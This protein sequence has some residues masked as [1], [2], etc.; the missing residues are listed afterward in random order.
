MSTGQVEFRPSERHKVRGVWCYK[1]LTPAGR[2]QPFPNRSHRTTYAPAVL[3]GRVKVTTPLEIFAISLLPS[4]PTACELSLT[5][6]APTGTAI[7]FS[8][9]ARLNA[10]ITV[11]L[12]S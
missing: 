1:H 7:F 11:S 6:I 8:C 5:P 3:G 12:L 4:V 10:M 9:A 2:N